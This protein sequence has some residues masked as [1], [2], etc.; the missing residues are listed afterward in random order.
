[1]GRFFALLWITLTL[2]VNV[3]ALDAMFVE[4]GKTAIHWKQPIYGLERLYFYSAY[5]GFSAV[6]EFALREFNVAIPHWLAHLFIAYVATASA[7]A[8]SGMGVARRDDLMDS[9]RSGGVSMIWPVTLAFF[10]LQAAR[11][12][13]VSRFARDHSI[14]FL[15]YFI[16]IGAN[17]A[18]L[19]YINENFLEQSA[20]QANLS[21]SSLS[22][23]EF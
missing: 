8:V 7:I 18:G 21:P 16:A 10:V 5:S 1:M 15:A 11:L 12:R 2:F 9:A 4:F 19:A 6:S 23:N 14:A 17:Y 22:P 20:A 13:I 3:F